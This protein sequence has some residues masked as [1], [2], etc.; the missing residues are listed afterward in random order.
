[1]RYYT[2][3]ETPI[4]PVTVVSD[5]TAIKIVTMQAATDVASRSWTRDDALLAEPARQ[6]RAYFAGELRAFT[7]PLAAH[8]TAFQQRV[9]HALLQIPYGSTTSYGELA[10]AI[11]SPGSARAVG[12]AN[13]QNPIGIIVPCHRVIGASGALTGYAGGMARK[14]WLL[15][16][17]A[18][19]CGARPQFALE[20]R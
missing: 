7:L 10:A 13:G 19:V 1:M 5:G 8:G 15:E 2:E 4:G 14:Q 16:H 3:I 11:G 6:L 12:A 9:W 18:R 20:L 17:E